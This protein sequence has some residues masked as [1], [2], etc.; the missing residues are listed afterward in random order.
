MG[1]HILTSND[2]SDRTAHNPGNPDMGLSG[3]PLNSW[4]TII[5]HS[6]MVVTHVPTK[7][8]YARWKPILYIVLYIKLIL[9]S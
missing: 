2:L 1:H 7:P 4:F 9:T 8:Y 5:L 3:Y 6:N